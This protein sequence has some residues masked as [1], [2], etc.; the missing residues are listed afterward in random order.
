M[1]VAQV[2]TITPEGMEIDGK[3]FPYYLADPREHPIV[4][5]TNSNGVQRIQVTIL[6]DKVEIGSNLVL[7]C[8]SNSTTAIVS[9]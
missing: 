8:S 9:T 7:T 3:V 4:V 6:A 2:I 1:K 5:H